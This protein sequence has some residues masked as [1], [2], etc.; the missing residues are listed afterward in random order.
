MTEFRT[1]RADEAA[2]LYA[3]WERAFGASHVVPLYEQDEGRLDRTFVAV[4]ATGVLAVVYWL[5][6]QVRDARSGVQPVG[7]LSSVATRPDARGRGLVRRL[8]ATAADAMTAAG[9]AWSLLFT[10]TPGV[11]AGSGW[12]VFDRPRV[13]GRFA[14]GAPADAG[15]TAEPVGLGDWPVLAALHDRYDDRRPLTT[16]RSAGDWIGRVPVWYGPP[17]EIL[18]VHERGTPMAYAVVDWSAGDVVEVALAGDG[19]AAPLLRA[20]A[21]EARAR[22]VRSGRLRAPLDPP[23]RAALPLLFEEWER[24]GERT[25]MARPLLLEEAEVRAVVEHPRAV[26]WTADYF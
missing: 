7:C 20:V 17:H 14:A 9:C 1:V 3:L 16:V 13:D 5:P 10:G 18:L 26:H 8:L 22:G 4:D 11:Y 15:W 2:S 25:G 24:R 12:R 23:V 6:R 21:A 19:A